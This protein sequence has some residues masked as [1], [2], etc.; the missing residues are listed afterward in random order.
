MAHR[1]PLAPHALPASPAT[2]ALS[3]AIHGFVRAGTA[4]PTLS[5]GHW[6]DEKTRRHGAE[7]ALWCEGA[8]VPGLQE[9]GEGAVRGQR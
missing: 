3:H 8:R 4:K 2:S 1:P 7:R 9:P 5:P 6:A